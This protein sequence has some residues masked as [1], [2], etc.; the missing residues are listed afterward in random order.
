MQY[1]CMDVHY[2]DNRAVSSGILFNDLTSDECL[3]EQTIT[4]ENVAPYEP[5]ASSVH[6]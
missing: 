4:V 3:L 1:F 2:E 5:Y 6:A